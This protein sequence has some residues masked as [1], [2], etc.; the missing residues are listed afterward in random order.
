MK[1]KSKFYSTVFDQRTEIV[2]EKSLSSISSYF[3]EPNIILIDNRLRKYVS[4]FSKK[5]AMTIFLEG[6]EATKSLNTLNFVLKKIFSNRNLNFSKRTKIVV[7]GGGT[8]GDFGGFLSHILKRGLPLVHVPSTW[9]SAIDSAHGGKNG[10]N[11]LNIKNQLGTIYP[12]QK[13]IL[14]KDLLETQSAER[15]REGFGELIKIAYIDSNSFYNRVAK[16][17]PKNLN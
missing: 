10:I 16:L 5:E 3:K 17:N 7:I 11:F 9:L 15:N 14:I 2:F 13:V 6:S 1:K 8:L 4:S 12:A